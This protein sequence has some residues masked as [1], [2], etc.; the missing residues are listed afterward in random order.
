LTKK[1]EGG[2][3]F[4]REIWQGYNFSRAINY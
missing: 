3:K 4:R 2:L 1:L